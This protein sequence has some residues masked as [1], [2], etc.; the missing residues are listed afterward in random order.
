MF[1]GVNKYI[2]ED[3]SHAEIIESVASEQ[4]KSLVKKI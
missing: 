1:A 2:I 3:A 4:G